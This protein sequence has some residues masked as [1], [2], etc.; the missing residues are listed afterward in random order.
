MAAPFFIDAK[1]FG[2]SEARRRFVVAG[3]RVREN[4]KEALTRLGDDMAS[5]ARSAAP[6]RKG[7]LQR[8]IKARLQERADSLTERVGTRYYV[9]RFMEYGVG[10]K[11]VQVR[12]YV[13]HSKAGDV[14]GL[15]MTKSGKERKG[16]TAK[17]IAFVR[18]YSRQFQLRAR[19]FIGPAYDNMKGSIR[20]EV[21]DAVRRA[22]AGE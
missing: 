9:A 6:Y 2:S 19:P 3:D 12:G 5:R 20:A 7:K 8:S 1:I 21:R 15:R 14:R 4:V 11:S 17:G 13:R 10:P 18:P 22:L 16:V